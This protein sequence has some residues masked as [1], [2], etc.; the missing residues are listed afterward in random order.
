MASAWLRTVSAK[1]EEAL[2]QNEIQLIHTEQVVIMQGDLPFVVRWLAS[3]QPEYKALFSGTPA[4]AA[5]NP[6]LPPSSELLVG[7][8]GDYHH[9]VLNKY[10]VC[11]NHLVLARTEAAQQL[12]PLEYQDFFA[13]AVIISEEGG[14]GFYNGGP[15]AGASQSHKHLQWI[16][17]AEGNASLLYVNHCLTLESDEHSFHRIPHFTMPH[18]AV[19]LSPSDDADEYARS[20]FVAYQ[21][22][23]AKLKQQLDEKGLMPAVNILMDKNWLLMVPRSVQHFE[24]VAINALSFGGVLYVNDKQHVETIRKHGPLAVL[25]AVCLSGS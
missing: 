19:R 16:P 6:F 18:L 24:K 13:L 4:L 15:L 5:T 11:E 8:I 12:E 9:L 14:L 25:A 1:R 23:C 3:E 10:P 21:L 20:L 2:A 17:Q 7:K 22:A